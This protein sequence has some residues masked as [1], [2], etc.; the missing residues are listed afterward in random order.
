VRLKALESLGPY[1][2]EDTS[3]RD[4]IL[5]ALQNDSNP[6][7]RAEAIHFL[8]PVRADSSVRQVLEKLASEDKSEFIRL[9]ASRTLAS[10][11]EID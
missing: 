3:V 8:Q 11:P 4:A 1:V 7:V 10:M 6:G 5:Q 9:Q 2:K